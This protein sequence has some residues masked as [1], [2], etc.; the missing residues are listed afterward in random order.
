M[1]TAGNT[2]L[3]TGGATGIGLALAKRF[4]DAGNRLVLVGRDEQILRWA[5][6]VFPGTQ[7]CV[8][9]VSIPADRDRIVRSFPD[10]NVLINNAGIQ[11]IGE[12]EQM[13]TADIVSEL[14]INLMAPV[15]L[16]HA[17]LPQLRQQTSAAVVNVSSMLGL[18]PKQSA[19]VYCASKAGVHS[20]TQSLRW[21]LEGSGVQV[22]EI[23]PLRVNT[24]MLAGRGG[25]GVVSPEA[26]AD[27]FWAC[28]EANQFEVYV[29]KA[30]IVKVL[31]RLFP[32]LVEK[33][34]RRG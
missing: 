13:S 26:L 3:I 33:M 32:S 31:L 15:L 5:E 21:Q 17:F 18:V 16:T 20:F 7:V 25:K 6:Q 30:K 2:V 11:R 27:E 1:N 10:V 23:V 8:A 4:Y 34:V 28:F 12:F 19:S 9:D 22:F 14:E 29:G 24:K